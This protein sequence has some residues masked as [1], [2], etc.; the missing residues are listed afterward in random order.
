[1]MMTDRKALNQKLAELAFSYVAARSADQ[2]NQ[3]MADVYRLVRDE[4]GDYYIVFERAC[5]YIAEHNA[6][7]VEPPTM[8]EVVA[9][10]D[11]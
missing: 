8:A 6:D 2:A 10:L 11:R 4:P 1:M 5:Y 9:W 7:F 3:V